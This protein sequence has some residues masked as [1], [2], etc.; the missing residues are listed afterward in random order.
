M[1]FGDLLDAVLIVIIVCFSD[2][3]KGLGLGHM[4]N[5]LVSERFLIM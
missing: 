1:L 4:G 5:A 3:Q 2:G